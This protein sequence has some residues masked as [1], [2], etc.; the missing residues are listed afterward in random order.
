[1]KWTIRAFNTI[2]KTIAIS[3]RVV[4]RAIVSLTVLMVAIDYNVLPQPKIIELLLGVGL[5]LYI[6]RPAGT[7]EEF[8]WLISYNAEETD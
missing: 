5:V 7:V 1:M 2:I 4:L 6:L 8:L 3:S